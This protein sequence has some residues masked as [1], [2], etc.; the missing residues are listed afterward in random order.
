[1]VLQSTPFN[2]ENEWLNSTFIITTFRVMSLLT[3]LSYKIHQ[4]RDVWIYRIFS[5][6]ISDWTANQ[7]VPIVRTEGIF[8]TLKGEIT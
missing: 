5:S 6:F 3:I 8:M 4:G 1:M 2:I 7:N